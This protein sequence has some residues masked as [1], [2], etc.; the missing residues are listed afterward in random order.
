MCCCLTKRNVQPFPVYGDVFWKEIYGSSLECQH[1][2]VSQF[3][4]MGNEKKKKN[5]DKELCTF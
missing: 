3:S 4:T 5:Q 1:L 2:I